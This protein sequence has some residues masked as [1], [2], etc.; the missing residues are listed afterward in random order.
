[1]QKP[2]HNKSQQ[3]SKLIT[4]PKPCH[5]NWNQMT[6]HEK[7]R[8]CAVCDKVVTDFTKSSKDEIIRHLEISNEN[9]CGKFLSEQIHIPKKITAKLSKIAASILAITGINDTV[10]SQNDFNLKGDVKLE[11]IEIT[12]SNQISK[13]LSGKI[14]DTDQNPIQN[15]KIS[16]FSAGKLIKS[17]L[18]N[19]EG[20]YTLELHAGTVIQDIISIKVHAKHFNPKTLDHLALTKSISTLDIS[21][22]RKNLIK[23]KR[24]FE[25]MGGAR[26]DFE[27][28]TIPSLE[29]TPKKNE[30][31]ST[32]TTNTT[33]SKQDIRKNNVKTSLNTNS[34]ITK[35][36]E[37][38]PISLEPK[39]IDHSGLLSTVYPNPTKDMV[40][41]Q[42]AESGAYH[43]FLTDVIG[44]LI[45]QGFF[46]GTVL[47]YS[48]QNHTP[49]IYFFKLKKDGTLRNTTK[50][51]V[52]K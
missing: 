41:I 8:H 9:T 10:Y 49:G 18:S 21:L 51:V 44:N 15:A 11:P 34:L 29:K 46:E 25:M 35:T 45:A 37:S 5:E 24:N 43:Y 50:V 19:A 3:T 20:K 32:K 28:T 31:C 23:P 17:I 13:T 38:T 12:V 40:K 14:N 7:G 30:K 39:N 16:V 6:P 33:S 1:M 42:L 26:I 52:E 36:T 2:K 22:D 48:F 47:E 27:N 4:I